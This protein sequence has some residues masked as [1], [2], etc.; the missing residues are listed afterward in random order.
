MWYAA[1]HLQGLVPARAVQAAA[2]A[3]ATPPVFFKSYG[4][5]QSSRGWRVQHA[6]ASWWQARGRHSR[7]AAA[8]AG[9]QGLLSGQGL[10]L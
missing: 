9:P 1:A 4:G 7:A 8:G 2:W 10:E 3:A 5:Y 6:Q